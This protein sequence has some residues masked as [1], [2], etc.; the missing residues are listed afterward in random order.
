MATNVSLRPFVF[1][2]HDPRS[3]SSATVSR[4]ARTSRTTNR[5]TQPN[6]E[7]FYK[8][9]PPR[10]VIVLSEDEDERVIPF[11]DTAQA[12][13]LTTNTYQKPTLIPHPAPSEGYN[14]NELYNDNDNDDNSNTNNADDEDDDDDDDDDVICT[15]TAP[16]SSRTSFATSSS[17]QL[18]PHQQP[19]KRK[20]SESESKS[21]STDPYVGYNNNYP[22]HVASKSISRA[23]QRKRRRIAEI[24]YYP[25]PLPVRKCEQ[26]STAAIREVRD[27]QA[28]VPE[29]TRDKDGYL[30]IQLPSRIVN[31]RFQMTKILGQGTFG[32]VF[33]A[34]DN[35]YQKYCAVKVIRAIPKYREAS[36][37][38][39]RV[40]FTI[41][42]Y[43]PRNRNRCIHVRDSFMYRGHM[44]IITDLMSQSVYDFLQSNHFLAFPA[45][46]VQSFAR[47]LLTS[48]CF[49]HDLGLVH[50][51]LKPENILLQDSRH[52]TGEYVDMDNRKVLRKYLDDTNIT[53]ID[54]GSA[55]FD[56]E[57]HH[58]VVSTRHYRAPEIL[59]GIG[60]SFP[61]D[62]WS[63]AC[64]LVELCTGDALFHTHDN[65]E[66]LALMERIL[67]RP[68]DK[69]IL[70]KAAKN[71]TGAPLVNKK[72]MKINYPHSNVSKASLKTLESAKPL[73]KVLKEAMPLMPGADSKYWRLFQ[74]LLSKMFVYD[75][76]K[77]ITAKE[78]LQH[79]WLTCEVLDDY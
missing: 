23:S 21:I 73:E 14:D 18:L 63:V 16:S 72:T 57:Y 55:I 71:S 12:Q 76:E 65:H 52:Q 20:K 51:D 8:N 46:H 31:G 2:D 32:K 49:L 66:H 43:D 24:E 47:Q 17:T 42:E 37:T 45:S 38:E 78:A 10:E 68:F 58:G 40:L 62:I 77:R 25:P 56:D 6:W 50:T 1:Q 29:P 53:L 34:Y 79:K 60:W 67:G 44:C 70:Q 33:A 54:F 69:H 26:L 61:C 11:Q 22:Q 9:G 41:K 15:G 5:S 19:L 27:V 3:S 64:I 59:F 36:K 35:Q 48:V 13:L 74:D 4:R 75:P 39:L 28:P 7:E 30:D